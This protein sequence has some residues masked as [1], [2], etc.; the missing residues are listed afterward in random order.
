M[1]ESFGTKDNGFSLP[2]FTDVQGEVRTEVGDRL[3]YVVD[4]STTLAG[5]ISDVIS[6]GLVALWETHYSIWLAFQLAAQ[7]VDLNNVV[8]QVGIYP[9][10]NV[11]SS[12]SVRLIGTPGIEV[13]AGK[14]FLRCSYR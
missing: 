8:S 13:P 5:V 9:R 10:A 6:E 7:G 1:F 3:G 12:G 4:D 14:R 2:T 11:K